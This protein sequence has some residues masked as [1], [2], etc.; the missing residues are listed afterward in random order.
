LAGFRGQSSFE[1]L[2]ILS[3]AVVVLTVIIILS[4]EKLGDVNILKEQED[5]KNA[6]LDLSAAAKEVYAQGEGAR[7]EVYVYLPSSYDPANSAVENKSIKMFARGT[8]YAVLED[9]D[10]RGSLPQSSG[11]HFIWVISE[12]DHVRIGTSMLS[13]TKNSIYIVMNRNTTANMSFSVESLW[14]KTINVS[15]VLAWQAGNVTASLTPPSPFSLEPV[16]SEDMNFQAAADA[17]A[18]GFYNGEITFTA[19]DGFGANETVHLPVTVEVVGLGTGITPPLTVLP[20]VWNETLMPGDNVTKT[21]TVCTNSDTALTMV[22]FSPSALPPGTWVGSTNPLSAMGKATCQP[23]VL[24]LSVPGSAPVG[25][26]TGAIVVD[27][28]GAEGATDTISMYIWV[29][30]AQNDT[31][32][33]NVTNITYIPSK[34][35]AN[36]TVQFYVTGSDIDRGNNTILGCEMKVDNTTWQAMLPNDGAYD[37]MLE[38]AYITYVNGFTMG[39]HTIYFRCSDV[40]NNT[41]PVASTSIKVMKDFLFIVRG[42]FPSSDEQLWIDWLAT[43]NS[44]AGF[45][46]KYDVAYDQDVYKTP[47]NLSYY[48]ALVMADYHD[49]T[50]GAYLLSYVAAGGRAIFL[51]KALDAGPGEVGLTQAGSGSGSRDIYVLDN[52]HYITE[53]FNLSTRYNISTSANAKVLKHDYIGNTLVVETSPSAY[54]YI[55]D[56]GGFLIWGVIYPEQMNGNGTL[57]TTNVFDYALLQSTVTPG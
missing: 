41:G 17:N 56:S 27:G 5:A 30:G 42:P 43:H 25:L 4:Q 47:I 6:V 55:G 39:N 18:L 26:Y 23:K 40:K 8:H 24:S 54:T 53:A 11:G 12:G 21:F 31:L 34:I 7:K 2:T 32:G 45:N 52:N 13:L 51:G 1:F 3:V 57:L 20:P 16:E 35:Y 15:Y 22:T 33:P 9:F 37:Q 10:V 29:G 49:K 19:S 50:L 14:D 28:Q 46:W 36:T 48:S 38:G 44:S